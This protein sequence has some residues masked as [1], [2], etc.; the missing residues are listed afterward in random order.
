MFIELSTDPRAD[1]P[2][3][4]DEPA[5]LAGFLRWQPARDHDHR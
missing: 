4:A 2:P 1:P 3:R 5:T